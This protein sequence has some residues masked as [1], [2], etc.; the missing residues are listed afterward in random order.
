M[1][2]SVN[3]GAYCGPSPPTV[4]GRRPVNGNRSSAN[5]LA[6]LSWPLI[7]IELTSLGALMA[8]PEIVARG[9]G[10]YRGDGGWAMS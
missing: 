10:S 5:G 3:F 8:F 4:C 7:A 9:V 6:K 1:A 2:K